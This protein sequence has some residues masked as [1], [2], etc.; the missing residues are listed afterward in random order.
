VIGDIVGESAARFR[1]N[2]RTL[3]SVAVLVAVPASL[4]SGLLATSGDL[5][6]GITFVSQI[7]LGGIILA[8]STLVVAVHV[9]GLDPPSVADAL[10]GVQS[11]LG[12]VLVVSVLF[13][14]AVVVGLALGVLPGLIAA[15]F[16]LLAIPLAVTE[17]RRLDAFG[18][19]VALVRGYAGT[20]FAVALLVV[21]L[22]FAVLPLTLALALSA[23]GVPGAVQAAL[24]TLVTFIVA[25]PLA[26]TLMTVTYF[27]LQRREVGEAAADQPSA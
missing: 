11:H 1:A 19:S 27:A 5:G 22:L 24:G 12:R 17:R 21:G 23:F 13:Q 20:A 6:L 2:W 14:V 26:A 3:L 25:D 15:T 7:V 8:A 10:R 4:L 18:R 16:W 9:E